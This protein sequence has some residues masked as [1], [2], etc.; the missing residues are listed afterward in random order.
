MPPPYW[1]SPTNGKRLPMVLPRGMEWLIDLGDGVGWPKLLAIPMG[2]GLSTVSLA[3]RFGYESVNDHRA[4]PALAD[5]SVPFTRPR[6]A[7]AP[8]QW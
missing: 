5:E 2:A 3:A 4:L 1:P 8:A 7:V 6:T